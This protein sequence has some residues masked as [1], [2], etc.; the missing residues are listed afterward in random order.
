LQAA[1]LLAW[2][3]AKYAKDYSFSRWRGD[4]PKRAPRKDF[5]SLMEHDHS[6][7]YMGPNKA[8]SIELWPMRKRSRFT[9]NMTPEYE[10]PIS[11]W[12]EEGDNIPII[13]VERS[14]GWRM[15][16]AQ[17]AYL[18][19]NGFGDKKFAL[20]FDESRLFEAMSMFLAA[21]SL[22]ENSEIMLVIAPE[23]VS[24]YE[25]GDEKI[26]HVK[27]PNGATLGIHLTD[28]ILSQLEE[29]L[30]LSQNSG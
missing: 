18:A 23:D 10:G 20:A 21:T 25:K 15:G 28:S 12:Y 3:C 7:F 24:F 17:F 1:D 2:Q 14:L 29:I 11:Y 26:L 19:F 30:N 13:P 16:G 27:I 6:L 9:V 22:F 5:L 4:E 8:M